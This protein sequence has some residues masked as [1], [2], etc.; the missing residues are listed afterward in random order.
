MGKKADKTKAQ[1][2]RKLPK[3]N[4]RRGGI[5]K[6]R[7]GRYEDRRN[8][9]EYNEKLVKRGEMYISLDFVESWRK[10]LENP[11]KPPF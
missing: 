7:W 1:S 2:D 5:R 9:R 4:N 10:E 11:L 3:H 6:K 8:W